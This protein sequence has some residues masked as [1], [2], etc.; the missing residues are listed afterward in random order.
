MWL[1]Y[2]KTGIEI[3]PPRNATILQANHSSGERGAGEVREALENPM[4]SPSLRRLLADRRPNSVAITISDITRAVPNKRFLPAILECITEAGVPDKKVV[5]VIGTGMHRPSTEDE[6]SEL[7]GPAVLKSYTVVDHRADD[8]S[9]LVQ[10][11]SNPYVAINRRFAE[12]GFKIVTGF[13]EPHFM[14]GYSGGRKGVCPALV[15][16]ATIQRF[17]GYTTL[18]DPMAREGVLDGNPCH[19]T[20]VQ[21]ANVVGVDFLFNVSVSSTGGIA[22]VYCGDLV[23]AHRAGCEEVRRTSGVTVDEAYDIVVTSGG[24]YPLDQTFYQTVKGMCMALP[25]IKPGGTLLVV[26]DCSEQLGSAEYTSLLNHYGRG[27]KSFLADIAA[28]SERTQKDQWEFQMQCRVFEKVPPE[29]V[30]LFSDGLSPDMQ[31]ATGLHPILGDRPVATRVQVTLDR[32]VEEN[33]AARIAIIPD[34][35][36]TMLLPQ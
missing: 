3:A 16:L 13:I 33:P 24:G 23:Q 12:A 9:T 31:E 29:Q 30:Y 11:G 35:P 2:G 34:G 32:L 8:P 26:S 4:G 15:D 18:A 25:A 6:R 17:H 19:E 14:A 28:N 10:V 7:V 1:K 21:V 20:A 27:W 22:D 5:I 36:Y